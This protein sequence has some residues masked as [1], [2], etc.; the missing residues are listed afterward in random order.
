MNPKVSVVMPVFRHSKEQLITAITSILNQTFKN[1]E[2][3][4]VDGSSDNKNREII[5]SIKDDRIKYYRTKGY[6]NCLNFGIKEAKGTYIA[7]MDSDDISFPN[8][9]E[10][11][12]KFLDD[13]PNVSLCS[14]RVEYFGKTNRISHDSSEITLLNLIRNQKFV[15][16]AM[17]FRKNIN[18][19]Y[20]Q[21][22]PLEDCLLFRKLL[23]D[24]HKFAIIDKVLLK[25]HIS[26]KSIMRTYPKYCSFLMSK[27][28]IWAL[29][30][31]YNFNLSFINKILL[32]KKFSKEEIN[33]YLEFLYFLKKK[34]ENTNLKAE[35]FCLQFFLYMIS[36]HTNKSFIFLNPL[37]YQTILQF[38]LKY[39]LK[40]ILKFIFSIKNEYVK[41]NK[42]KV[43]CILGIKIK[44]KI[45]ENKT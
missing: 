11:Q 32:S 23:L 31:Y 17:M 45:Q 44:F 20:D 16:V 6:I 33:E 30:K 21:I 38:Y 12:V 41:A 34:T 39:I 36:K 18:V 28:N 13:N 42:I 2:L 27:I 37:F 9:I 24:G 26:E 3:I 43:I 7:R 14:C 15:H 40:I 29:A 22:K 35:K 1:I 4:I 25:N 10:E 19:Q 8:R 5:N